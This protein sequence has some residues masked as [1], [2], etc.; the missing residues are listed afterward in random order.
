MRG[1]QGPLR[2]RMQSRIPTPQSGMPVINPAMTDEDMVRNGPFDMGDPGLEMPPGQGDMG[3]ELMYP[4]PMEQQ[5]AQA[6]PVHDRPEVDKIY[7]GMGKAVPPGVAGMTD[8]YQQAPQGPLKSKMHAAQ[9]QMM[10]ADQQ[11]VLQSKRMELAQKKADLEAR[12][13]AAIR[14]G[15][16]QAGGQQAKQ[17]EA[18]ISGINQMMMA[19]PE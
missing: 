14:G 3:M 5:Q 10:Q 8:A 19:V 6:F 12:L 13:Q 17:I 1:M 16:I 18:M 15:K 7:R 2:Q 4:D 9:H 11:T